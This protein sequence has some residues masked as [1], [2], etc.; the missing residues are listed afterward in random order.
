MSSAS[1]G[2]REWRFYVA[3]MIEFAEKE[4]APCARSI[5]MKTLTWPP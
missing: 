3:D 4:A 2:T 5:L 1:E